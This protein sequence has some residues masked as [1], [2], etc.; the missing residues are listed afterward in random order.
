MKT[1][2]HIHKLLI[3]TLSL[4][5]ITFGVLPTLKAEDQNTNA[6]S[7]NIS[8]GGDS[9]K[10]HHRHKEEL[11]GLTK[12]ER[13]QL[14]ADMDKVE[15]NPEFVAARQAVEEAQTKEAKKAAHDSL[16]QI[17]HKLLLSVDPSVQPILDKLPKHPKGGEHESN[18]AQ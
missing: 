2:N 1:S 3:P 15:S 9:K 14:K 5:L 7:S 6:P 17:R 18:E 12:S 8:S 11:A 13:K 16:H 10:G 4:S